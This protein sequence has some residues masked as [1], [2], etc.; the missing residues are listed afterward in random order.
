MKL[1]NAISVAAFGFAGGVFRGLLSTAFD[2]NGVLVANLLGCFL[3]A[4]LTYYVIERDL[5][6]G[7]LNAGLGTGL[8]G[9]FTTFSS[10]LTTTIKLTQHSPLLGGAYLLVS[11]VGGLAMAGLGMTLAR[12]LG[13]VVDRHA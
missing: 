1:T 9:A 2:A 3:L 4:F 8:I 7:W 5:L 12:R 6:A 13:R 11:M 10:F